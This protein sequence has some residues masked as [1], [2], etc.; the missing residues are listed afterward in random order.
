M[1]QERAWV[2]VLACGML[3]VA[4]SARSSDELSPQ[5]RSRAEQLAAK[6][7]YRAA[8]EEYRRA[9]G[10]TPNNAGLQNRLGVCYQMTGNLGAALKAYE[11][12]LKLNPGYAEVYNNVGTVQH[13]RRKYRKAVDAYRKALESKPSMATAH[14]NLG[15]AYLALG[16][17]DLG[18]TAFQQALRLDPTAFDSGKGE[19]VGVSGLNPG[20]QDFMLA[21][22]HA[23]N[24][25]A[26]AALACLKRAQDAGFRDIG[27]A[28]GD[29]DFKGLVEDARFVTLTR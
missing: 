29:P 27:K 13:S 4:G 8:I 15:A 21:K 22:I 12:A 10:E 20:L 25:D 19:A 18:I 5:A 26:E 16:E 28:A 23:R 1:R 17:L 24:G 6:G 2:A 11:K 3:M 9:V 7:N 14:K